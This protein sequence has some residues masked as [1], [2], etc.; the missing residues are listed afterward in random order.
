MVCPACAAELA[1][2][3]KFCP[4][5]GT[6]VQAPRCPSCGTPYAPN[7]KFCAECGTALG[8]ATGT[9]PP[10]PAEPDIA[11]TS[12]ELRLVSV[13]FVDLVGFTSLSE[14]RDAEEVRELL[15]RYFESA[16]TIVDRYA[17]HRREV[18]RRRRDGGLGRA[19]RP[20]GRRRAGRSR[21][22]GDPRRGGGVRRRGRGA[23]PAGEGRASSTGQVAALEPTPAKA[24]SSATASTPPRASSRRPTRG[25]GAVDDVTHDSHLGRDRL[26]GRRRARRQGQDRAASPVAGGA[27]DRGASA[28]REREQGIE[29]PFVG[30]DGDL[31]LL[32]ELLPRRARAPRGAAGDRLRR[33]RG[34]Q[35]AAAVG[36]RQ[37][38]RRA[39]RRPSCGTRDAAS[40]TAT[41]SPTGR[42]AEMIRQRFGI[43][44]DAPARGGPREARCG[45]RAVG[46]RP[47]RPRLPVAAARRPARR[48]RAGPR[49]HE[50]FAGWRLFLERLAEHLPVV[51]VFDDLQ[52]ADAG[53]LDFIEHCSSGRPPARSSSSRSR[54]RS[55]PRGAKGGRAGGAARRCWRS[56]RST[57][58]RCAQLLDELV[59]GLPRRVRGRV[60]VAQAEG[61]PLYA[62]ETIRALADRGVLEQRDGRLALDRRA[63]RARRPGQPRLAAGGAP[64][65]AGAATSAAS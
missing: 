60:I 12:P 21:R 35:D 2:A 31:R 40:R 26:R 27:R 50:L 53:L 47:G 15:G 24:W 43:P 41:G 51:L 46:P 45:A 55:S 59:E 58:A 38:R 6:A 14:G 49:P 33:G 52:W 42:S 7:Q 5:C 29:A 57:T 30:R 13:L 34:R 4:E 22:P 10:V 63:R 3:A 25:P 64:G 9:A 61:V 19:G 16:R 20:R 48:R 36:V 17:G 8:T 18:H 32:K 65:R 44:E 23:G 39:A 37:V 1:E 54:G 28:G 11:Q 56:S 62:I